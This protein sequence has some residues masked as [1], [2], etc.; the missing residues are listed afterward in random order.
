M[1][2]FFLLLVSCSIVQ[3]AFSQRIDST[4]GKYAEEYQ[5]EKIHIH[6][7]KTIYNRGETIWYKSYLVAGIEPSFYSKNFYV[8]WFDDKG[9][10]LK[11]TMA[12]IFEAS[13]RG[14]FEI[15]ENYTGKMLH[16]KAYTQWMLNFDT[17]FL[18][19]KDIQVDQTIPYTPP[20]TANAKTSTATNTTDNSTTKT[21][22]ADNE[23]KATIQFFPEGGEMVVGV[24]KRVA[25]LANNQYGLPVKVSGAIKNSKDELIDSF[26]TE[27]NG[28]GSVFIEPAINE[29]YTAF[30]TDEYGKQHTDTLPIAKNNTVALQVQLLKGKALFFVNRTSEISE[31]SKMVYV[32]AHMHQH[33]VYK[34]RINLSEKMATIGE[35]P[36]KD[37]PTGVLQI[38]MFDVN[39]V[40]IAERVVFVNNYQFL[41]TPEIRVTKKSIDKRGKNTIEIETKDSAFTNMSVSI[42]DASLLNNSNSNIVSS[43]LLSADVK[44]YIHNPAYYFSSKAD[45]VQQ[46]LDLVMLTH[47]WRR[48]KW[49]EVTAGQLPFITQPKETDYLQLKGTI[50]G[51]A[52]AKSKPNQTIILFLQAKDSSKQ[53][54]FLPVD[55]MGNFA[56][57]GIMFYDTIKIFYQLSGEKSLTDRVEV[58]FQNGLLQAPL[59][60]Y[61]SNYTSPFLLPY[62]GK[63][64]TLLERSKFFFNEK[65]K[66]AKRLAAA[67]LD[68]VTVKTRVKSK[69]EVLDEKYASGMFS[70]GD[71]YQFDVMNDPI[72][73]G[74]LDVFS[75]LQGRVAGLQINNS[76]GE[77]SLSW[78]GGTPD[79][80]LDEMRTDV[81]QLRNISMNDVA[82][83]K[84]F[85]P[86]FFGAPGGGSGGAIAVYTRKG[87]DTKAAPGAGLATQILAGYTPYKEFYNPNYST[88]T[89]TVNDV[90]TTLYWNPYL[91]TDGKNRTVQIEF[92]NNDISNR[93]RLIIEGINSDGKLTRVE[94]IIE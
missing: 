7:D 72:A 63:D 21:S 24:S 55:R 56:Q 88:T 68:E 44:G 73:Q 15:P 17:A 54:M 35:I 65:E 45:S 41:F 81:D 37:L 36:T 1:K 20:K 27:H 84:V 9:K 8:D 79:V 38:T 19:H 4:M 92:Y 25:F 94:K 18:F 42:T 89:S 30:W 33:Q 14:Q 3:M 67:Q 13:A 57:K 32:I 2:R 71:G 60:I 74:A 91:L 77:V 80:F 28:M 59:K 43:L 61:G 85:R 76:G 16:A 47:G 52:Y 29:K 50:Y 83:I 10:L 75:Y 6:F 49:K 64:S 34:S 5:Q 86:P 87:G 66:V 93:F 82:Y 39:Y 26:I 90:R 48:F 78:R 40:P 69:T 23:I 70:G 12:P 53:T 62:T 31:T 11:H 58:R 22:A 51:N 46:H